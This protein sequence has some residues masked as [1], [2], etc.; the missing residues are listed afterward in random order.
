MGQPRIRLVSKESMSSEDNS[1]ATPGRS[2]RPRKSANYTVDT[3]DAEDLSQV[4][5]ECLRIYKFIK[6]MEMK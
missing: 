6:E 1:Q 3:S 2:K 4:K 5:E